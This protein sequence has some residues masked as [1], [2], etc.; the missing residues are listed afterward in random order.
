MTFFST[1]DVTAFQ[2]RGGFAISRVPQ[3]ITSRPVA[4]E[5]RDQEQAQGGLKTR[6]GVVGVADRPKSKDEIDTLLPT[7]QVSLDYTFFK[8]S[9]QMLGLSFFKIIIT[10]VFVQHSI[11][12]S[13]LTLIDFFLSNDNEFCI[14]TVYLNVCKLF[15]KPN[16]ELCLSFLFFIG[17]E[18]EL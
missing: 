14:F 1:C 12:V 3:V 18:R 8:S 17:K 16:G 10:F 2:V 4:T 11:D 7:N 9:L 5:V 6:E 15:Q 13:C